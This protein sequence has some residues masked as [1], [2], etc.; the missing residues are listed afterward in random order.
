[1]AAKN[2][3]TRT[4]Q[5]YKKWVKEVL[6]NCE[7]ICYRCGEQI[8]M[9]LPKNSKWGAS[10]E[11]REAYAITGDLTPSLEDSAI[12]HLHC[13]RSHGGK[14]GA[15]RAAAKKKQTKTAPKKKP[16]LSE[17]LPTPS[18]PHGNTPRGIEMEQEGALEPRYH[19]DGF[20]LPRLETK[21]PTAVTGTYGG[22][23]AQW[24]TD[25]YGMTLFGWQRYALDRTLEHDAEG[26]LVWSTCLI[27]VGRQSGKSWLSRGLCLWRLHHAEL[28]GEEQSVL[29]VANKRAVALEV[30]RPAGLW[31]VEKYGKQAVRWGNERAGLD[32]PPDKYGQSRWIISA[33]NSSAGVGFSISMC[34]ADEAF[35]IPRDVIDQSIAPTMV[36]REQPQLYLVST[37]GDSTSDLMIAYRTRA[38]D[39]LSD[40]DGEGTLIL[41]WSAPP[42]AHPDLVSTWKWGSPE[43]SDKR[44]A[45]LKQ[46]HTNVEETSFRTQFLNQWVTKANHWLKP[47]WWRDT[48][49]ENVPLPAEGVWSIAV[50]SDFDGQGHAVAIAAPNEEGHIVT[51]VTTHRTM[52]QVDER[53]AEIRAEHPSLYILV[54]PGYVDRLT[55]RFDG[56]VGQ[57]EAVAATQVLQDLFS[58]TQI[59][60]NGNIILQEHFAGTRIGMRQGGWVLTSPMGSSGIYAARATMFAIS[61]AAKTPRGMATIRSRRR[62]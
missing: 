53:L 49:D 23:A 42:E 28:F 7:P 24:L 39:R 60:H 54:T 15:Q 57:R 56:L 20:I 3:T 25:V 38:I 36:M 12:S 51:R 62:Q 26:K 2:T 43:W 45:F 27:S 61:Q 41:E 47:S 1:M 46:Q 30:F 58:R 11:H 29:H 52:K 4:T 44:E 40:D 18:A 34:F 5:A 21:P 59:R 48:L 55:S 8:D 6:D 17:S 10:A 31:A 9:T 37:A 14:L 32:L 50:E 16:F 22:D 13:N 35:S 19:P 33:S